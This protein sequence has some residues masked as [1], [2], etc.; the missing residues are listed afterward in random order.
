MIGFKEA[1]KGPWTT[2]DKTG[3]Q[4]R[5]EE[6]DE[7]LLVRLQG[8]NEK[9]PRDLIASG[10]TIPVPMGKVWVSLFLLIR[11][12]I[13]MSRTGFLEKAEKA[14]LIIF[15]NFSQG[16][17]MS[18]VGIAWLEKNMP[19]L[20]EK[21]YGELYGQHRAVWGTKKQMTKVYGRIDEY[22]VSTDPVTFWGWPLK[23]AG[24]HH[25]YDMGRWP[26]FDDHD[27]LLY[28]GI[29]WEKV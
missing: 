15:P 16:A 13:F 24:I 28:S 17:S 29:D 7:N 1:V 25:V 5:Y 9:D 22:H 12:Y 2:I 21:C 11:W 4:Y 19:H 27:L 18:A 6:K 8:A 23:L 26:R 20:H 14:Y 3:I 10:I